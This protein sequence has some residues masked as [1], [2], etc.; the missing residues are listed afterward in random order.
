MPEVVSYVQR[1]IDN[2]FAYSSNGSVYFD[3][4]AFSQSPKHTYGKL[5][6]EAVGDLQALAEGE[7]TTHTT[8]HCSDCDCGDCMWSLWSLW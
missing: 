7:G 2:G 3:V 5:V 1:I 8:S 6:P 4:A